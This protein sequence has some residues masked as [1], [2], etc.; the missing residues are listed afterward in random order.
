MLAQLTSA[1]TIAVWLLASRAMAEEDTNLHD[2]NVAPSKADYEGLL[3]AIY[4]ASDDPRFFRARRW[5]NKG[6]CTVQTQV[7]SNEARL[8]ICTRPSSEYDTT[9]SPFTWLYYPKSRIRK[10]VEDLGG[11]IACPAADHVGGISMDG[12]SFGFVLVDIPSAKPPKA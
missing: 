2:P 12:D 1:T 3:K 10:S 8:A 6:E 4:N 7:S 9:D 11:G 5:G